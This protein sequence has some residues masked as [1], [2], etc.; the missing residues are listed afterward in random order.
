MIHLKSIALKRKLP[1]TA[2]FPFGVPAM[3][4]F[5]EIAFTS[6]VTFLA[7]ENGSGKST[8]LEALACATRLP[9]VG[10][11][12]LNRDATLKA[13]RDFAD[14]LRLAWSK[15]THRGFFMRS[16]DF[17]GF[18]KRIAQT[19]ADLESDLRAVDADYQDRSDYAKGL[20]R[21]PYMNELHALTQSYGED[22]D[23]H[24]HGESYFTLFQSRF[25][26]NG[27]YLLDEPEA[28]LSP[29]RQLAFLSMLKQMIDLNAQFII[30]THSPILMAYPG[31]TI[32]SFDSGRIEAIAYDDLEHVAITRSFLNDPQAYLRHLME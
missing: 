18:V 32:L 4:S 19:R 25:V 20:A 17:F 21:M 15:Q 26:P 27:L 3:K 13:V 2:A 8:L 7:G 10:A 28:P 12:A 9:A 22:L 11:D 30:A 5:D 6:E 29:N 16:E 23:H 14:H 24:S 1:E 31:A